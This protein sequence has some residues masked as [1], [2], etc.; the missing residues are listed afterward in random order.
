M[1][2]WARVFSIR[3]C[4][5]VH[6]TPNNSSIPKPRAH[7]YVR[8]RDNNGQLWPVNTGPR[9]ICPKVIHIL[10][11]VPALAAS[12]RAAVGSPDRVL[13]GLWEPPARSGG[14]L[15]PPRGLR[16]GPGPRCS[17]PPR[18]SQTMLVSEHIDRAAAAPES[19]LARE[20]PHTRIGC[21]GH[22]SGACVG[23]TGSPV[24]AFSVW[25]L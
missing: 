17:H 15:G 13:G 23:R 20:G 8:T 24:A 11:R 16:R 1:G 12:A 6:C 3:G 9:V 10:T 22:A 4:P 14:G 25:T 19:H 2:V 5:W 21:T 7:E 18:C